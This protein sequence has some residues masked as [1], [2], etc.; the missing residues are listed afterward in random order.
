M[1]MYEE[2]RLHSKSITVLLTSNVQFN[3]PLSVSGGVVGYWR[4]APNW[5]HCEPYK[6]EAIPFKLYEIALSLTLLAMTYAK[7]S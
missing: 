3:E 7:L 1:I 5:R 6:G 4:Q 2:K